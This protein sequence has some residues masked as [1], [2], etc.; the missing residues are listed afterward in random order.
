MRIC[1]RFRHIVVVGFRLWF[2][3]LHGAYGALKGSR[4]RPG[5]AEGK[6][7][8]W[9]EKTLGLRFCNAHSRGYGDATTIYIRRAKIPHVV[10]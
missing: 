8:P 3:N 7:Q 2:T 10:R 6:P 5:R 1:T 9:P 4:L